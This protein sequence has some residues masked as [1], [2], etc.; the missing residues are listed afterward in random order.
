MA[1]SEPDSTQLGEEESS[2]A[3]SKAVRGFSS[4]NQYPSERREVLLRARGG[5]YKPG[6]MSTKPKPEGTRRVG[7]KLP[8]QTR[9][10]QNNLVE[11]T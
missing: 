1:T 9:R 4:S 2:L 5:S 6:T 3:S 11:G 10:Q 8:Q 7:E